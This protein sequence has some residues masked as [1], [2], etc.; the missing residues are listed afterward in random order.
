MPQKEL[1]FYCPVN[2]DTGSNESAKNKI[3]N[4]KEEDDFS[5]LCIELQGANLI[6][7]GR[8]F[9]FWRKRVKEITYRHSA[10]EKAFVI[11]S[12]LKE[13]K[14]FRDSDIIPPILWPKGEL[15]SLKVSWETD[16]LPEKTVNLEELYSRIPSQVSGGFAKFLQMLYKINPAKDK[17]ILTG[18]VP[19][20]LF[21]LTL[22]WFATGS[23]A[24]FYHN[25]QLV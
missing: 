13:E 23:K 16:T 8:E 1:I 11:F 20:Y 22:D 15:E 10:S 5:P 7:L 19:P 4:T 24:I 21:L 25:E 2:A 12:R 3:L 18:D 14:Y 17:V 9:L 6:N